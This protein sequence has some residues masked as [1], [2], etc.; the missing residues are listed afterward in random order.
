MTE[1][2]GEPWLSAP[3]R[4]VRAMDPDLFHAAL[5]APEP[6]RE[7]LMTLYAFDIELSRAAEAPSE[8]LIARMR[9]QFW[10]DVL[11]GARS[12]ETAK[13][14]E[15]AEPLHRLVAEQGLPGDDLAAMVESRELELEGGMDETRFAAW[16]GARFGA[17]T[18]L[19][20]RLL[21]GDSNPAQEAAS[22][23]GRAIGIAFALRTAPPMARAG[24]RTLLPGL[25]G[26][27]LAALARGRTTRQAR[28]VV[29]VIA[30][31]G[32]ASLAAARA[33]RPMVPR[34]ATPAFLPVWRAERVLRRA[35]R[36]GLDMVSDLARERDDAARG[37]ALTWR[38]LSGRW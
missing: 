26:D 30:E 12:G 37:L 38:A 3:A 31:R 28:E 36:P 33:A 4:I 16:L 17:L 10:R 8:P 15:V 21:G 24:T 18:R 13:Q 32:L 11:E 9:L 34:P 14:H 29:R 1:Q 19:A 22:E 6:G 27:D 5:F 23:A 25:E 7:R 35:T 2:R 20:V